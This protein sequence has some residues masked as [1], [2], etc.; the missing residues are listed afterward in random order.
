MR[1]TETDNDRQE[2]LHRMQTRSVARRQE[3]S[4][5]QN[6]LRLQA[7]RSRHSQHRQLESPEQRQ[8][9][10][11]TDLARQ[12]QVRRDATPQ[13]RQQMLQANRERNAQQRRTPF[14]TA[15][16]LRGA[17]NYDPSYDYSSDKA[18]TI[19]SMSNLCTHC[20]AKKWPNETPGMCCCAGKVHL[21]LHPAPPEPLRMLLT[22]TTPE[23]KHFLKNIRS[24]NAA[25]QMTSFGANVIHEG[26]FMPTF[27]VQGQVCHRIGSLNP[28][29]DEEAKFL[30]LYFVGDLN[31]QAQQRC[32]NQHGLRMDLTLRLQEMIHSTNNY[33]RSFKYALE[34]APTLEFQV[35]IDA[36]KRPSGEHQRRFNAPECNEVAVVLAD[37]EH[38]KR[39]IVL[40]QR[41]NSLKRICE[42][43]RSYDALQYPLICVN[44]EDGYSINIP[45][46]DP[47]TRAPDAKKTVSCREFYAYHFMLRSNQ[48]NALQRSRD[49]YNQ[50]AVDMFAKMETERLLFIR[51]HQKE[52][53]VDSY[54][55]LRDGIN[56]DAGREGLGQLCILPSSHTGS[57]RYMHERTQ[58]AMTYVRKFGTPDL[59]ITF[60][61]NPKWKEIENELLPGQT[62][63]DRHDLTARVFQLKLTKLL[64]V[65]KKCNAF[66]ETRCDMYTIEWQ[67]RGLPHAHILIWLNNKLHSND[68]DDIISAELP[69]PSTD[70]ELHEIIKAQMVHGPCGPFNPNSPCMKDRKCT[71]KF[72]RK[73]TQET[74]TGHDGYPM[75][76][77]RKPGDG[78]FSTM[79]KMRNGQEVEI[80]NRWVVPYSPLLSKTFNAHINVEFCNSVKS[81]KYVC[82]YVNKGSDAAM[83]GLQQE[84]KYDE[85][86]Q[87][88]QGR[89]ISSNEAFWRIFD[90]VIHKRHPAIEQLSVH[91]ENGQRIYFTEATVR[92]QVDAPKDTTLTA[93]FKLCQRDDFARTL[94]YHEV[95]SYYTWKNKMWNRR[96]LGLPV[97]GHPGVRFGDTLGRVY[98]VHPSQQEC[99]F[100]RLL[101]HDVKG[102]TAFQD[103]KTVD[104]QVCATFREACFRRG[105][106]ED[107]AQWEATMAEA[108]V[109]Q[110]PRRLRDLFAVLLHTCGLT[111]PKQLWEEFREDLSEDFKHQIQLRNPGLEVVFNDEIFNLALIAIEDKVL[112][113][114]GN[115]LQSYGLPEIQITNDRQ[116]PSEVIRETCYD[117]NDL[118]QYVQDNEPKLLADQKFAYDKIIDSVQFQKGGIFFL[119][120]PGGTGKTFVTRLLLAKVR[121]N[122]K[123]ALAVASSGIAAT[124][125]PGGRTAHSAFKLPLNLATNPSPTC[126]ISKG[127]AAAEVL[128]RCWMI[129]WDECTMSHKSA[130]EALDRTLRDIKG[131]TA[132]FGGVTF[133]LAGDFRQTLP[134]IPKGT[135]ADELKACLKSSSLWSKVQKLRL[136]TNMRAQLQGDEDSADFSTK[137]LQLGDGNVTT[138]PDGTILM[139]PVST[140]VSST[141]ELKAKVFP[142][143]AHHYQEHK[144]LC[145]RAI[146]APKNIAVNK[147]NE[148][149]LQQVPGDSKIYKS[150]DTVPDPAQ[151]VNYPTEFLNS[152]EPPGVPPHSFFLKV[153]TPIMLLRNL[154]PPRMCNGTRLVVK[155]MMPHLIEATILTGCGAGE[156]VFIPRIPIIPSDMAFE[157]KRL[158]FPIRLSFAMS[159][160]KSQGQTLKVAGLQLEEPCFSHGQLYVAASRV[161]SPK[162]LYIFAPG[163][164]TK[165]I[166]YREALT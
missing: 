132:L 74:Q 103:L 36:N 137:L 43:H 90:Y 123:I 157:F 119:D 83:F 88:Q 15:Q 65:I 19:G 150:I 141:E 76:R 154:E 115:A 106:L 139:S 67:K 9:R 108:V 95:P 32:G 116:L 153:G 72:P 145:E 135:K 117:I 2:R 131:S 161:G 68:I 12:A 156:D 44:G 79:Q 30:Q 46:V 105:L 129:V 29:P 91:L 20:G 42:T 27:K 3:E 101:L 134:V 127:T 96:K 114:G 53:R 39:D 71:K 14:T 28:L 163:G 122:Q 89:Y 133:V 130:F 148:Q 5:E 18:V 94:Y 125:L 92:Q 1:A 138:G 97:D 77:R 165:N 136:S 102:P 98:T 149:M 111:Q 13:Q 47:Q 124:L 49:L 151:S 24:Y 160:N 93:F 121:Q 126:N 54:I 80:D 104:G 26:G 7:D 82:K 113:L 17:F 69:D 60:T 31:K 56:N 118:T 99:F 159:I 22:G 162:N 100:L 52:L 35:V 4:P 166:V 63:K 112:S 81:I 85:V 8:L 16:W 152:L 120:A 75:Y 62:G 10:L 58:D 158:Q 50:F 37:V 109:S 140:L 155:K 73:L 64:A 57:P 59:F 110:S 51:N 23:S 21:K 144:W 33:V 78:G 128:K 34:L 40:K 41:D 70:R 66:G 6:Q 147:I 142:N 164:R 87:Y 55:H 146:L 38:G 107:D 25:F 84:N 143:I 61:C 45:H 11:Q 86:L 48:F